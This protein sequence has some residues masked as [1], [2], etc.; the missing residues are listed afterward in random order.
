[1]AI[2]RLPM[3][4]L[5][6]ERLVAPARAAADAASEHWLPHGLR[7]AGDD[8]PHPYHPTACPAGWTPLADVQLPRLLERYR[9]HALA[10]EREYRV[11][12]LAKDIPVAEGEP[13]EEARAAARKR[14][15]EEGYDKAAHLDLLR[16]EVEQLKDAR[17][18]EDYADLREQVEELLTFER[19][20][21]PVASDGF[22]RLLV[23]FATARLDTL[24]EELRRYEGNGQP[25]PELP[26]WST[27]TTRGPP[28]C[29]AGS[30]KRPR[31]PRRPTK[32]GRR[33]PGS[34]G[35]SARSP[36]PR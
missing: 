25:D 26:R 21:L 10:S 20:W 15:A 13:D 24:D 7:P 33:S 30:P 6:Y 2:T 36:C 9:A 4:A 29:R 32:S 12:L 17:A 23:E 3:A 35:W 28:P 27:K 1:M 11:A 22:R 31:N 8:E 34:S 16:Q 14:L 18:G 19:V 5:E